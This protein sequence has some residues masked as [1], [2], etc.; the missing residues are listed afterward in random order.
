MRAVNV[1]HA[2][3]ADSATLVPQNAALEVPPA[4][5][6]TFE[7]VPSRTAG[8]DLLVVPLVTFFIGILPAAGE[9]TAY[10]PVFAA[11]IVLL[12]AL[13]GV[14][15]LFGRA[16][17]VIRPAY[18]YSMLGMFGVTLIS[19]G[20]SQASLS[21]NFELL[22]PILKQMLVM[23]V[24]I[25]VAEA[26]WQDGWLWI[27]LLLSGCVFLVGLCG[28]WAT[29][30]AG[31]GFI[32]GQLHENH[33]SV[34]G[35]CG[36]FFGVLGSQ[37]APTAL[38]RLLGHALVA[39][40]VVST[41]LSRGRS[42][43]LVMLVTVVLYFIFRRSR[44]WLVPTVAFSGLALFCVTLPVIYPQLDE[45]PAFQDLNAVSERLFDKGLF[46]GRERLWVK[47][48]DDIRDRPW[49]GWG[50]ESKSR[51]EWRYE[52]ASGDVFTHRLSAHNYYLA[53]LHETGILGVF[54]VFALLTILWITL[55][56]RTDSFATAWGAAMFLGILFHQCFEVCL[57]TSDW[58]RGCQL[59]SM[60]GC[61]LALAHQ[62]STL[63]GP[64]PTD[65]LPEHDDDVAQESEYAS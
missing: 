7:L 29:N 11:L 59:W 31:M 56:A 22:S 8:W 14:P 9:E 63:P 33:M 47:V 44:G 18:L 55:S 42:V 21:I 38:S 5:D 3:A 16:F 41:V 52:M 19:M 62:A 24:L 20:A 57:T 64:L 10:R 15:A 17:R 50:V 25:Y 45:L 32:V 35:M 6:S 61:A 49:L 12:G 51:W 2:P 30:S 27:L 26:A 36:F 39:M 48:L 43:L 34:S 40:G 13:I 1:G 46:S 37:L 28:L 58:V 54:S 4:E 53:A 60:I 65:D 23:L